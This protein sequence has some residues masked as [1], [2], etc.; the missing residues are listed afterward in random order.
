MGI[1]KS[2]KSHFFRGLAVLLPTMLTIWIILW[3]Y[4]FIQGNIGVYINRGL[5]WIISHTPFLMPSWNKE[6]LDKFWVNGSGSI[7]GFIIALVVVCIVGLMLANVVGKTL[8]RMI[9]KF[10]MNTPFLRQIYPYIKQI[11]DFF[12][13]Q[14]KQKKYISR[15]VGVE[16]PRK[17]VWSM[18]FVTGSGLQKVADNVKKEFLTILIPT[19]PTPFTGF[20]IMVPK[21]ETID[22][23]I[24]LEEALRFAVSGGVI[25]PGNKQAA[26]LP[27]DLS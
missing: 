17:G 19:S 27:K 8:W 16:Y 9:E 23:D 4:K 18:G 7:T 25:T 12:L 26:C 10:I 22:L 5:V 13:T 3:G 21:E 20:T 14:E 2:F 15:I 1:I 24:T 11:T 6:M